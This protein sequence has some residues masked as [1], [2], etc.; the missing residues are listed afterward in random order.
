MSDWQPKRFWK[1]TT[2]APTDGGYTVLLDGRN[3]KTPAK[4]PLTV[5]T[6]ALAEALAVEWDAQEDKVDPRTMPVTRSANAAIDKVRGQRNEVI[7]LLS[8]YA[9]SDLLCYRAADPEGL[10]AQQRAGWDPLL[11]WASAELG[12]T[13][14]TGE[15]VMH[16]AQDPASLARLQAEIADQDEYSLAATHDLISLSGSFVL[17]VAVIR[18]YLNPAD[19]WELSRIDEQW[20]AAQWGEDE[21]AESNARLKQ[22]AFLHAARFYRL[23]QAV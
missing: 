12:A 18:Q 8:E 15:G 17:A 5:P 14:V 23:S 16:I 22:A 21:E 1:Q 4:A 9:G 6:L 10:V 7:A 11:D 19:A 13:L 20:Q 3:V 2:T